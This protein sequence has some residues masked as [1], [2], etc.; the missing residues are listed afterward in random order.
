VRERQ[1]FYRAFALRPGANLSISF[2]ADN[3][4]EAADHARHCCWGEKVEYV[5][6]RYIGREEPV[7]SPDYGHFKE[8]A[9]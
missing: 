9:P 4:Q 8:I 6:V 5:G 7:N 1:Q 2:R 3:L